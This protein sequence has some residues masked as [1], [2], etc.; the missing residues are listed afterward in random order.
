MPSWQ[1]DALVAGVYALVAGRAR[2]F[3]AVTAPTEAPWE[4][5]VA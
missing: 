3:L 4:E 2:I 5:K 1:N